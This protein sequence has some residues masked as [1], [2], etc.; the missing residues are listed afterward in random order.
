MTL[1]KK[2][3]KTAKERVCWLRVAKLYLSQV[4]K[5]NNISIVTFCEMNDINVHAFRKNINTLH[6]KEMGIN[7]YELLIYHLIYTDLIYQHKIKKRRDIDRYL[8]LT[9]SEIEI[10][11]FSELKRNYYIFNYNLFLTSIR[12]I[13]D[14]ALSMNISVLLLRRVFSKIQ[15][16]LLDEI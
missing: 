16:G 10:Y 12:N 15:Q 3:I 6:I 8:K 1:T 4:S 2:D 7:K 5:D 14:F 13:K 9:S 11:N